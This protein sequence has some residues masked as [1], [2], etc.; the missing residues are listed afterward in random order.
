MSTY[1]KVFNLADVYLI[2]NEQKSGVVRL[3][4]PMVQSYLKME[5]LISLH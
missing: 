2:K 4:I 5:V 3:H 1:V